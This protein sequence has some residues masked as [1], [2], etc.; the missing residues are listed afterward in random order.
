MLFLQE[1]ILRVFRFCIF[2]HFM[3]LVKVDK[4]KLKNKVY[5]FSIQVWYPNGY[6]KCTYFQHKYAIQVGRS[7]S[8][9]LNHFWC[10]AIPC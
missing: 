5:L 6:I 4:T 10:L 8:L 2:F 3:F 7:K 9:Y 1:N